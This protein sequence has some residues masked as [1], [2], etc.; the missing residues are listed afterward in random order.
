MYVCTYVRMYVC[1]TYV[2]MY[3]CTYVRV[4]VYVCVCVYTSI[5]VYIY[6]FGGW[7]LYK[8][9]IQI[10]KQLGP[11]Q[12]PGTPQNIKKVATDEAKK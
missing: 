2:R 9:K 10:T 6:I 1:S 5:Y 11:S 12:D 7:P 3:V 4:R 8:A